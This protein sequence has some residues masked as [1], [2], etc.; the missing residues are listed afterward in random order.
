MLMSIAANSFEAVILLY[1]WKGFHLLNQL[2]FRPSPTKIL[3]SFSS[4]LKNVSGLFRA[5]PTVSN[6]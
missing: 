3:P 5:L 2:T 6:K 1:K 4:S